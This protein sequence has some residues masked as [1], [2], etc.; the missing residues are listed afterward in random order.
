MFSDPKILMPIKKL[1]KGCFFKP[2]YVFQQW[3]TF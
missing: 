1:F 2:N 3:L